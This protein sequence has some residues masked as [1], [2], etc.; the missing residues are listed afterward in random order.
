MYFNYEVGKIYRT[1]SAGVLWTCAAVMKEAYNPCGGHSGSAVGL[2]TNGSGHTHFM[3]Y[4]RE[5][6]AIDESEHYTQKE[7]DLLEKLEQ[8]RTQDLA[9]SRAI[10]ADLKA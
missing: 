2:I 4:N 7:Y 10:A 9:V 5:G 8:V 1:R 3:R 6:R